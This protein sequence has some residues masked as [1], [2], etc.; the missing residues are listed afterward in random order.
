MVIPSRRERALFWAFGKRL[1][2]EHGPWVAEQLCSADFQRRRI[3][4]VVALQLVL[5]VVPQLAFYLGDRERYHLLVVAG[6][7]L[8]LGLSARARRRPLSVV[9]RDRLLGHHGLDLHGAPACR[10]SS[11]RSEPWLGAKV[12]G[13]LIAQ[14]VLVSIGVGYLIDHDERFPCR[15]VPPGTLVAIQSLLGVDGVDGVH[16]VVRLGAHLR[17][18]RQVNL[19]LEGLDVV[20]A[21][22][23]DVDGTT[24]GPAVWQVSAPSALLGLTAYN[25]SAYDGTARA[26][27]PSTG[28]N[29]GPGQPRS[30]RA[31]ECAREAS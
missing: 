21:T 27:T 17:D 6:L 8:G 7:L 22:V 12:S 3:V 23:V 19:G 13:L 14:V 26:L 20:A 25:I 28:Y 4:G 2:P 1:A 29:P 11:W 15:S 10:V 18:A 5:I 16:S 31:L 24:V 9:Q 30:D